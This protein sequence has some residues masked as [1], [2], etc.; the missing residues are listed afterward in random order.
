MAETYYMKPETLLR[1]LILLTA[2]S[3]NN[4]PFF[5]KSAEFSDLMI[6]WGLSYGSYSA[7]DTKLVVWSCFLN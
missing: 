1:T 7:K 5:I 4:K 3:S 6:K 2:N